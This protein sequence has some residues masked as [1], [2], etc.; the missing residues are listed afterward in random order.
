MLPLPG[1]SL[2]GPWLRLIP[3]CVSPDAAVSI[4]QPAVTAA[5]EDPSPVT[6]LG[7]LGSPLKE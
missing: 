7:P 4:F 3:P 6:C 2:L 5:A 1:Q